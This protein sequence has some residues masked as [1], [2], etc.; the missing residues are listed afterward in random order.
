MLTIT[1][2]WFDSLTDSVYALGAAAREAQRA[3]RAT[4]LEH[5]AYSPDRIRLLDAAVHVDGRASGSVPFRPHD[6]AVFTIGD[7]LSK[8]AQV[9]RELY[10]NT[11]LAY[12][13]GTAWAILR[14]LE[15][16]QPPAV[17]LG[18]TADGHYMLPADLCPVPPAMPALQRW[19]DYARFEQARL[20]L[21]ECDSAGCHAD[22]LAC[23]GDLSDHEAAELHTALDVAAGEADAAY[24]YGVLAESAL[25]FALLGPKARHARTRA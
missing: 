20:R 12:G 10:V 25:H 2:A 9:L 22:F 21:V 1:P 24:A 14:V 11:A 7:T 17:Q 23:Q 3:A 6:A 16:Q 8:T 18:R 13:Y 19:N 4:E 15:G 5:A